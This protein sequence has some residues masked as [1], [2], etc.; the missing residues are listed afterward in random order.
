[1]SSPSPYFLDTCLLIYAVGRDHPYREPCV[2]MLEAVAEGALEAV[3]DVEVIQEIV[4]RFQG[5]RRQADG[6]KWARDF[7]ETVGEVLPVTLQEALRSL[8]LLQAHPALSPRDAI[9]VAV[10]EA[11][12]LTH[13][14]TADRH[15]EGLPGLT[16]VDPM[17]L[18]W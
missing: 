17:D 6:I 16:R 1:M 3:T 15:F 13:I 14:I 9:H 10:M 5:L 7:V 11:A 4:H 8:A 2:R 12:G 18:R